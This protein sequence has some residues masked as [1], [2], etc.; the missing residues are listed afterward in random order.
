[1]PTHPRLMS[2]HHQSIHSDQ[3]FARL[4]SAKGAP[5]NGCGIGC[6][7]S[8]ECR[9]CL[10]VNSLLSPEGEFPKGH[11]LQ[12][13][14]YCMG[15]C[16]RHCCKLNSWPQGTHQLEPFLNLVGR[17]KLASWWAITKAN[18]VDKNSKLIKL[19]DKD[20]HRMMLKD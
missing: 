19:T 3:S 5:Q 20:L 6:G 18:E 7:A 16:Q 13:A 17:V 4:S 11:N 15:S 12:D 1:M 14:G 8:G 9:A 10:R 2:T